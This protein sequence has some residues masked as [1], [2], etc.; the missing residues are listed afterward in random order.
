MKLNSLRHYSGLTIKD[1]L[2][3]FGISRRTWYNREKKGAPKL[4]ITYFK[5]RLG[6]LEHFGWEG[7]NIDANGT[8]WSPENIAFN[9][10]QI[11]AIPWDRGLIKILEEKVE[12][13]E[14]RVVNMEPLR[15][16]EAINDDKE[17]EQIHISTNDDFIFISD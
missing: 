6:V 16:L 10:N 9:K 4:V 14:K 17:P 12:D 5:M 11:R 7:W 15:L 1:T 2:E 3:L 8:L 13:L